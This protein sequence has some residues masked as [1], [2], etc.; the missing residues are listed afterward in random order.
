MTG[1]EP[2]QGTWR[3]SS[4]T[5]RLAILMVGC[6]GLEPLTPREAVARRSEVERGPSVSPSRAGRSLKAF[7]CIANLYCQAEVPPGARGRRD[8]EN[9]VQ[10]EAWGGVLRSSEQAFKPRVRGS[11]PRA[12]TMFWIRFGVRSGPSAKISLPLAVILGH[13]AASSRCPSRWRAQPW[14]NTSPGP[15]QTILP[16]L[17]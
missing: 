14:L 15:P 6:G 9:R 16:S 2:S 1:C 8:A 10:Q 13:K 5:E 11:S 12:G 4:R 7:G 3:R 17:R